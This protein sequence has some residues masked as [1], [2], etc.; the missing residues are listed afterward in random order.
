MF[1]TVVCSFSHSANMDWMFLAARDSCDLNVGAFNIF[2]EVS[3]AVLIS[4]HSFSSLLHLFPASYLPP[5]LAYLLPRLFYCWF[6]PECFWSQLLHYSL[7]INSFYFSRSLLNISC[8]F[9]ILVSSLFICNSIL[10]SRFWIIFTIIILN[11]FSGRLPISSSFVWFGGHISCSF[12]CW[13]SLY[14]FILFRLLCLGCLFCRL[15]VYGSSL[16]WSLLPMSG[17]RRVACP[18]LLVR[19]AC[20]CVLMD[21][22]GSLLSEVQWSIQ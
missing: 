7:L 18:G 16:L 20:V 9:S 4:L 10:F 19:W 1:F 11:S 6:S 3:E 13:I 8:I 17:V 2:P 15:E 12:T 5:H 22:A 21:G 14:L